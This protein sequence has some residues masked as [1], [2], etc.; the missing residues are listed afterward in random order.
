MTDKERIDW[1]EQHQ[2]FAL[3]SDDYERWAC[4]CDGMQDCPLEE[5]PY[6][7]ATSFFIKK[8]N[9]KSSLREAIDHA[10]AENE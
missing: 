9:W 4:V 8:D 2:G 3:V 7:L 10:I 5:G 6:D 1:L